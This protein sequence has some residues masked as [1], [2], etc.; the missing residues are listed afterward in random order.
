M[1]KDLPDQPEAAW[2][3]PQR[4]RPLRVLVY[5]MNHAP[6]PVGVGRYT[7]DIVAE[8]ARRG[9]TVSVITTPPHYP[10]WDVRPWRAQGFHNRYARET[11][12]GVTIWRC[13]LV[14]RRPM[15]GAWRLLAPLSFAMASAPLVVW[16]I[17]RDRPD[18]VVCVE[19]TLLAAPAALAAAR[20][21][22]APLALHVHDLEPETATGGGWTGRYAGALVTRLARLR[23]HFDHVV[24]L[25]PAMAR[26]IT[27]NGVPADRIHVQ[28]NWIDVRRIARG[29]DPARA[30]AWRQEAGVGEGQRIVLCAGS[31][32]RKHA[33]LLLTEA[34]RRLRHRDDLIFI[35]AGDGPLRPDLQTAA[36]GLG[37]VR[38]LPLQPEEALPAL[39]QLADVHVMPLH[40]AW[41]G[42][43]LPSRLGGMLASGKL[44]VATGSADSELAQFLG[45][46]A[47]LCPPHDVATLAAAIVQA[48]TPGCPAL[49]RRARRARWR[50]ALQLDRRRCLKSVVNVLESVATRAHASGMAAPIHEEPRPSAI[51][52]AGSEPNRIG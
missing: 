44:V 47:V 52:A 29:H 16:R 1:A 3:S 32:N 22:G 31:I 51:P 20:L 27:R 14:L 35:I 8:L 41:D 10:H 18:L 42:L 7:A 2:F 19:P 25:S 39:L 5:G 43:A 45:A 21:A 9:H 34:A 36:A 37:N 23:R 49:A 24:T 17:L 6:E 48:L 26:E 46:A 50:K 13:P 30:A 38:F 15:R 11:C 28:P 33:P 4:S 40:P 12:D